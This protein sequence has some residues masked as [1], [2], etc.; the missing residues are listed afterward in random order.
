MPFSALAR[1]EVLKD[2]AAATYGSDAVA[3]VVNFI[4][5]KNV[6]GLEIG[7]DYRQIRGSDG[8]Y[9]LNAT[10]G[11]VGDR[12]NVMISGGFQH[13]SELTTLDRSFAIRPFSQNPEGNWSGASFPTEFIPVN[14]SYQRLTAAALTDVACTTLG[15]VLTNPNGGATPSGFNTCRTQSAGFSDLVEEQT[16]YQVYSE[17]NT[18]MT[19]DVNVHLEGFYA[20]TDLPHVRSSASFP[21]TRG[22]TATVLPA[23]FPG[24]N[25]AVSPPTAS[26]FYVPA[27]NPG[28]A[29]Y[30]A[31]NPGVF[32]AGTTGAFITVGTYRPFSV[33]GNPIFGA[34]ASVQRRHEEEVRLSGEFTGK[35]SDNVRWTTNLTYGAY[36]YF[37]DGNDSYTGR[38]ALALRGLGGPNCNVTTGV[39]GQGGC[40]Y[41]NPFSNGV[42][43]NVNTGQ[44][45]PGFDASVANSAALTA[46]L[47]PYFSEKTVTTELEY[48]ALLDG[49]LDRFALPGGKI[50]WATGAQYRQ[51]SLRIT[52]SASL[53]NLS[54]PCPD[55]PINGNGACFPAISSPYALGGL[56]SPYDLKQ[57]IY[58]LFAETELPFTESVNANLGVR[59]EDYGKNGGSTINPQFRMKWQVTDPFALRGSVGS[60]FRAPPQAYLT[61]DPVV[62]TQNVLGAVRPVEVRGNPDLQPETAVTFSIGGIV[63]VGGFHATVDYY[64]YD[65]K[66]AITSEPLSPVLNALFP[67]NGNPTTGACATLDPSFIAN[68]FDFNGPCSALNV[69]KVRTLRVN[70]PE[71]KT[72]GLDVNADYTF[73]DV[74]GGSLQVGGSVT[75]IHKYELGALVIGGVSASAKADLVGAF[76]SGNTLAYPL[77]RYKGVAYLNYKRGP[78][79]FRWSARYTDSYVDNRSIFTAN[80]SYC[81]D[82]A[83][84]AGCGTVTSGRVIGATVLHDVTYR[85]TLPAGLTLTASVTNL[86]DTDP[87]FARTEIGYDALTGDPLGRTFKLGVQKSF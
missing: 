79:N 29:S 51:Y 32:P 10:W 73:H 1:V 26:V 35:V 30:V 7:G 39:P 65:L 71:I 55:S 11:W 43:K 83:S 37:R 42:Q 19:D 27:S 62:T 36:S 60:T 6:Q 48:N 28:F 24:L 76:N 63:S 78:H 82:A 84:P 2:G 85:L 66:K 67:N 87:S 22:P 21:T 72:D 59:Y 58:A 31:A 15:G 81:T 45:N 41:L 38:V 8:D 25:T 52:P 70:G 75:Y 20:H 13:R 54:N 9:A 46:W 69:T 16:S 57:N 80:P 86:F 49:K 53:S 40:S 68:H 18:R 50:S 12:S 77:P 3:G 44:V 33:G 5:R 56:D 64:N 74:L 61:P 47:F 17:L 4:T 14:A 23:G 34:N